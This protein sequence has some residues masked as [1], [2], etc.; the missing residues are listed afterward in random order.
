MCLGDRGVR[1]CQ[2]G[3]MNSSLCRNPLHSAT[4]GGEL[5]R[6]QHGA[7]GNSGGMC[8]SDLMQ[9]IVEE[10]RQFYENLYEVV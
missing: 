9:K 7:A 8:R 2:V 4:G 1:G 3:F 5:W 6:R 10:A